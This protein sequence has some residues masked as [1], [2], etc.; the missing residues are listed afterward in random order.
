MGWQSL[1]LQHWAHPVRGVR[2]SLGPGDAGREVGTRG[3][4]R[5]GT[6]AALRWMKEEGTAPCQDHFA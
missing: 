4:Q 2:A 6:L 5:E 3:V 1:A